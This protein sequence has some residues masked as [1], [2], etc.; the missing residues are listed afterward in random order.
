LDSNHRFSLSSYIRV[1]PEEERRL[2]LGLK[3]LGAGFVAALLILSPFLEKGYFRDQARQKQARALV[4]GGGYAY[5]AIYGDGADPFQLM[6][7]NS[8]NHPAWSGRR[9]PDGTYALT[10]TYRRSGKQYEHRWRVDVAEKQVTPLT[11]ET[12]VPV[13]VDEGQMQCGEK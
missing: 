5:C 1:T 12:S 10:F 11:D 6:D 8:P 13:K 7:L 3:Q 9:Q 2:V 4:E